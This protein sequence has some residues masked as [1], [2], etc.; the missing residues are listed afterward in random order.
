MPLPSDLTV[1]SVTASFPLVDGEPQDGTVTFDP[2]TV[3][4]DATGQVIL[5]GAA[6]A[7]VRDSVMIPVTLPA[8]DNRHPE[9]GPGSVG[10]PGH[11]SSRRPVTVVHGGSGLVAGPVGGPVRAGDDHPA[12]TAQRVRG[13]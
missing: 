7:Q 11:G 8:T 3:L 10:V 12:T 4:Q 6:T 9:P 13:Q 5:A 2:G 1:V